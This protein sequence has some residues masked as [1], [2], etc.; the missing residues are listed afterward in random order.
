MG[1]GFIRTRP[2]GLVFKIP[3]HIRRA[4]WAGYMTLVLDLENKE[5]DELTVG[6][7]LH[8]ASGKLKPGE[9]AIYSAA[10]PGHSRARWRIPLQPLRYTTGYWVPWGWARQPGLGSLK[11][12]GRMNSRK[13][14]EVKIGLRREIKAG[15]V[16]LYQLALEDP[17]KP[18]GWVDKYGQRSGMNWPGKVFSDRDII[19]ADKKEE[20]ELGKYRPAPDRDIF[21]AWTGRG[22][23]KATGFFRVENVEGRWWFI[24]PSG[25]LFYACGLDCVIGGVDARLDSTV[26]A[27]YSWLPPTKGKFESAWRL[28]RA[29]RGGE[30]A[31]GLSLYRANLIRKWGPDEYRRWYLERAIA[32]QLAW[33]FT[34][35]GNWADHDLFA[36]RRLPYFSTGPSF[37]EMKVPYV[38]KLIHDVYHPDFEKEAHGNASALARYRN[39]PWLVGHFVSNEVDWV[40][41]HGVLALPAHQPAKRVFLAQLKR[42][43][44]TVR[45]LNR[46]WGTTAST[47]TDVRWPYSGAGHEYQEAPE[48]DLAAFRGEFARRWYKIW[49]EAIRAADPNHLVLGS[50]LHGGNRAPEL[51]GACARHMDVVSFNQYEVGPGAGEFNRHFEIAQKPFL[52]GEY[53]H[54][55]LDT[56]LLS[57]SVPVADQQARGVGYRYYTE[58]LAALPYFIGGHYFQYLDEPITGR[59][60]RETSF[61]GFVSIADIPHPHLVKAAKAS[62]ARIYNVHAGRLRPYDQK[63]TL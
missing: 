10:I 50:R 61:N 2:Q 37:W 51:V 53:G 14:A 45:N 18:E 22:P 5:E 33:G 43:Y 19:R 42:R 20:V 13:I 29:R 12:W 52:I 32:R 31:W 26:R 44:G 16:G 48:R 15:Q 57:A 24:A 54:N 35:I 36:F 7:T 1:V 28:R 23:R 25:R 3:R 56:G 11:F 39:D 58:Q 27:A 63:P 17:I 62:H 38:A 8:N 49:G 41:F 34:S 6:V 4:D 59:F 55:S 46:A 21:H 47:F 40:G 9:A 60:D 30:K